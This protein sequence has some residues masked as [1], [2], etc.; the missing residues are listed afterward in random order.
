M[1]R[2]L[3]NKIIFSSSS[4]LIDIKHTI[5][6]HNIKRNKIIFSEEKRS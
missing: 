1:I 6:K 2:E 4:Y 5:I 3:T